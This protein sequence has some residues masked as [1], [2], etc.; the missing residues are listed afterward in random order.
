MGIIWW[1][2]TMSEVCM[3]ACVQDRIMRHDILDM[4]A[5]GSQHACMYTGET[6]G[7]LDQ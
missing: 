2:G 7:T 4:Y 6:L 5:E 3:G 1:H